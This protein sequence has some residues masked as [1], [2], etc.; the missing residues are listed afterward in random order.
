[1]ANPN[2]IIRKSYASKEI[3]NQ[4]IRAEKLCDYFSALNNELK[5]IVLKEETAFKIANYFKEKD[6]PLKINYKAKFGISEQSF[7]TEIK[8]TEKCIEK[9][10]IIP[11]DNIKE[12]VELIDE[13]IVIVPDLS[14]SD[15]QLTEKLKVYRN[16]KAK[17]EGY[18]SFKYHLVFS[19]GIINNLVENKPK[20]NAQLFEIK[21]LAKVKINKYGNDI[22]EIIS[23]HATQDIG[24]STKVGTVNDF[25]K[26]EEIRNKLKQFRTETARKENIKPYFVFNNEQMEGIIKAKPK[27][28]EQLLNVSGFGEIKAEKYS[29]GIVNFFK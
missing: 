7:N 9:E 24:S 17:E 16:K 4:I 26:D 11:A 18:N 19:I 23:E 25:N 5:D 20:T 13:K 10:I 29:V 6:T 22:L 2:A 15:K 3:Q 21:G 28:K 14:E 27:T 1:M 12:P 8:F